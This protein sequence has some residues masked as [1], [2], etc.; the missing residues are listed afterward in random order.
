M[1]CRAIREDVSLGATGSFPSSTFSAEQSGYELC[2]AVAA[3]VSPLFHCICVCIGAFMFL[4]SLRLTRPVYLSNRVPILAFR[5]FAHPPCQGTS[6]VSGWKKGE[7]G[8]RAPVLLS[9]STG[10]ACMWLSCLVENKAHGPSTQGP[11]EVSS[12]ELR[13][14]V[15]QHLQ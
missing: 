8:A 1:L 9:C 12:Q 2:R 4:F 14:N 6:G 7:I 13:S 3:S 15:K 10:A 5:T 11:S